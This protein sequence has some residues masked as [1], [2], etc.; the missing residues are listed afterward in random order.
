MQDRTATVMTLRTLD[1]I[2]KE[3]RAI[4]EEL[5]HLNQQGRREDPDRP[6]VHLSSVPHR[7]LTHLKRR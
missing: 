2:A 4:R 1:E 3:L 7:G 6:P 5:H